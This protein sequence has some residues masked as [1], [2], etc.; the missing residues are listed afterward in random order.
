MWEKLGRGYP[1]LLFEASLVSLAR[2]SVTA[3]SQ[4]WREDAASN[5][6]QGPKIQTLS[7]VT[8]GVKVN[9]WGYGIRYVPCRFAILIFFIRSI[10]IFSLGCSPFVIFHFLRG[11]FLFVF[12]TLLENNMETRY[13][14]RNT[15]STGDRWE[16]ERVNCG[17]RARSLRSF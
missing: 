9:C 3:F 15:P 4:P 1:C 6:K 8:D 7:F 13:S 14:Y 11:S 2:R 17:L 5:P 10:A 12:A 16:G